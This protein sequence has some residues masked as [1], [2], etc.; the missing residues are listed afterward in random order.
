MSTSTTCAQMPTTRCTT[1]SNYIDGNPKAAAAAAAAATL[2]Q[3]MVP[4]RCSICV[5][6]HMRGKSMAEYLLV[7]LHSQPAQWRALCR[8]SFACLWPVHVE[9]GLTCASPVP[10]S[11]PPTMSYP[12][13]PSQATSTSLSSGRWAANR[14]AAMTSHNRFIRSSS[15]KRMIHQQICSRV[16]QGSSAG[17]LSRTA[18]QCPYY[19]KRCGAG[20]AR[21]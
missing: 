15:H 2:W 21:L 9:C 10:R 16:Q 8:T 12:A 3:C 19:A 1:D 17:Q 7:F 20:P 4:S 11:T 14:V 6:R 5:M 18:Q 13:L